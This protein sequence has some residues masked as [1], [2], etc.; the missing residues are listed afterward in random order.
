[1]AAMAQLDCGRCGYLCQ[2]YAE[3]IA[4]GA[5]TSLTRCVPGGRAT[6]RMLKELFAAPPTAVI[7]AAPA[8]P[9]EP[10]ADAPTHFVARPEAATRLHPDG[11]EKDIRHLVFPT[12]QTRIG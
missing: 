5:E 7:A 10:A 12:P 11:S 3:A 2:T 9:P 1:M 4:R 6:S 8:A